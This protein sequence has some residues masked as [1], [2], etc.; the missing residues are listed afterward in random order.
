MVAPRD[1]LDVLVHGDGIITRFSRELAAEA[2]FLNPG[3]QTGSFRMVQD[4][5]VENLIGGP[6][7]RQTNTR[8]TPAVAIAFTHRRA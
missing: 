6:H 7:P 3:T 8:T 4:L 5:H 1:D 2:L